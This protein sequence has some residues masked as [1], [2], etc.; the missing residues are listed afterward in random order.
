[1]PDQNTVRTSLQGIADK[2]APQPDYRFRNLY[3][4]VNEDLLLDSWTLL[5]QD[6]ALGVDG[7]S[8][9]EYERD[10]EAN[11]QDLVTRLKE[12]QIGRASCRERV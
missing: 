12:K 11:V 7:V 8:A 1:M 5:R 6:A 2:A 10:L 9:Q 3:G 4:L